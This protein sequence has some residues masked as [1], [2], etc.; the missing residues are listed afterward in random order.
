MIFI[1]TG[2]VQSQHLNTRTFLR[3][4]VG[5]RR[6]SSK[7]ERG[8]LVMFGLLLSTQTRFS[9]ALKKMEYASVNNDESAMVQRKFQYTSS[10]NKTLPYFSSGP[11]CDKNNEPNLCFIKGNNVILSLLSE[12][13]HQ[14]PVHPVIIRSHQ[15]GRPGLAQASTEQFYSTI[16]LWEWAL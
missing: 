5:C 4:R 12:S 7:R 15:Y 16:A 14:T 9:K 11:F 10:S 1:A 3:R 8:L 2:A 13:H 6:F